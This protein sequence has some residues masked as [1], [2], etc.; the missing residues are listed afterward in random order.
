[1]VTVDDADLG[2]T[3][4]RSHLGEELD[5]GLVVVGPLVGNVVL[6]VD[7]LDGADGLART[8]VDTLVGLDVE[9]AIALVDAVDGALVDAGAIFEI[10]AGLG[11]DVC[12][13]IEDPF[14][15][16]EASNS[17]QEF[18]ALPRINVPQL[19]KAPA[20]PVGWMKG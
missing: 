14:T 4:G 10:D 20:A 2:G 12:H 5:V 3:T 19:D 13:W 7:R 1:M 11:D 16:E 17:S 15:V 8:A 18:D 9:H 6:V